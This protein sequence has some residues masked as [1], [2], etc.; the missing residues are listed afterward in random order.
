[1]SLETYTCFPF[2]HVLTSCNLIQ[3]LLL[4]YRRP[5]FHPPLPAS[6]QI[7]NRRGRQAATSPC[8]R[9]TARVSIKTLEALPVRPLSPL[10]GNAVPETAD[11][12]PSFFFFF[13][14]LSLPCLLLPVTSKAF[15]NPAHPSRA[16]Y[17]DPLHRLSGLSRRLHLHDSSVVAVFLAYVYV[18]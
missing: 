15:E 9:K 11:P 5:L 13:S 12:F 6:P 10:A 2:L 4:S 8:R 17:V 16:P 3:R 18:F 14:F 1:M 7:G